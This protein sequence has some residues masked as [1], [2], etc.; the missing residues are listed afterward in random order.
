[1]VDVPLELPSR[2]P[3]KDTANERPVLVSFIM[4]SDRDSHLYRKV[5]PGCPIM[6]RADLTPTT[7]AK[8]AILGQLTRW[9]KDNPEK[10]KIVKRTDHYVELDGMRYNHIEAKDFMDAF[11]E[12]S[13]SKS[14]KKSAKPNQP[15]S[16]MSL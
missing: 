9:A 16:P 1:M 4:K 10:V 3:T 13:K 2:L 6:S 15:E 5:P 8:R 11:P 7:A 14:K 12:N